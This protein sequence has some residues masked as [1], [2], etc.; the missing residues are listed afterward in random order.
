MDLDFERIAFGTVVRVTGAA[1][2]PGTGRKRNLGEKF[3]EIARPNRAC[4]H[5][6]LMGVARII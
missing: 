6:V 4:F 2:A 5:E 1:V 3:D